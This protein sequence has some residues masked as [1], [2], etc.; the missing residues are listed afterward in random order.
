VYLCR[1]M[2]LLAMNWSRCGE[3]RGGEQYLCLCLF[4]ICGLVG[5]FWVVVG[6]VKE[7]ACGGEY[8]GAV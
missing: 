7:M 5:C 6:G 4:S 3:H 2:G 8:A 1:E